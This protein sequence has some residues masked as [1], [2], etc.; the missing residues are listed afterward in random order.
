[1]R[2]FV[3]DCSGYL[4]YGIL[5]LLAI[6]RVVMIDLLSAHIFFEVRSSNL[7]GK[8]GTIKR[9]CYVW[10]IGWAYFCH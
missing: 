7:R 4:R 9:Q 2:K 1:M 10:P 6:S 5:V 3:A 8:Y